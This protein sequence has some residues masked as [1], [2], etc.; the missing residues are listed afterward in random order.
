MI[1]QAI[2]EDVSR[3]Q[4]EQ[5]IPD[6]R[7]QGKGRG[8]SGIWNLESADKRGML[9]PAAAAL[10]G[11]NNADRH[12]VPDLPAFDFEQ[13]GHRHAVRLSCEIGRLLNAAVRH[14]YGFYTRV[15]EYINAPGNAAF[16][17]DD[18]SAARL[19]ALDES[20]DAG[21]KRLGTAAAAK[22]AGRSRNRALG[23]ERRSSV[24]WKPVR[25]AASDLRSTCRFPDDSIHRARERVCC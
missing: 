12:D 11:I 13:L 2:T 20:E 23:V 14:S 8:Q 7:F 18:R 10:V 6:F 25:A 17:V 16:F 5:L 21:I 19:D 22:S 3:L 4:R 15:I 9:F 24:H 1:A